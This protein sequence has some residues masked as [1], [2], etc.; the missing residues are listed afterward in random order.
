MTVTLHSLFVVITQNTRFLV[1][2]HWLNGLACVCV[3]VCDTRYFAAWYSDNS[4]KYLGFFLNIF[5]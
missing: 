3:C 1:L 5:L 4:D 2:F